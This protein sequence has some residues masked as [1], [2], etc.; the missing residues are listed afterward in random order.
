MCRE[1]VRRGGARYREEG[2]NGRG[3]I[4][5]I[6]QGDRRVG[7]GVALEGAER[8]STSAESCILEGKN[9]RG[10]GFDNIIKYR[11]DGGE[12]STQIKRG[13]GKSIWGR[14][15]D[16]EVGRGLTELQH[17]CVEGVVNT[18]TEFFIKE[19]SHLCR[20]LVIRGERK[21]VRRKNH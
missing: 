12:A 9:V 5:V 7:L 14:R 1:E 18:S 17:F 15:G 6:T 2:G 20:K 4:G 16:R 8:C 13:Y 11:R 21:K 3:V 19:N 10:E